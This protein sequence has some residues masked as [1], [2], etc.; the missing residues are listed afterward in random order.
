M[1][2]PAAGPSPDGAA[3]PEACSAWTLEP[4]RAA[5][6]PLLER[7]AELYLYDYTDFAA[8]DVGE[9]GHFE[10]AAWAR[11]LW[12]RPGRDAFL[13]RVE[14]RPAGFAVVDA[15]S[16]EPGGEG[17]RYLAEFFVLRRYRRRGLGEAMARAV[18]DRYP[19]GWHVLQI[20]ENVPAQ[21]FWRRVIS[22][23]TGGRF[24]EIR[25]RHGEPIQ[26]FNTR[27]RGPANGTGAGVGGAP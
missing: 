1:T 13:L 26:V 20:P 4:L 10:S 2:A 25:N 9:D 27:D 3:R 5:E 22:A 8:W 15:R 23:Y 18:F 16:P 7:L 12:D 24:E 17:R 14:G 6:R 21:R 19:G 11:R